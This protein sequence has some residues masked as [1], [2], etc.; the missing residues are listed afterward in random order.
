M[1]K[2]DYESAVKAD[3]ETFINDYGCL[4]H[5]EEFYRREED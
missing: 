3:L 5:L 4:K 2:Y 1:E